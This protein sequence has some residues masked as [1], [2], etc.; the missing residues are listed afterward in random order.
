MALVVISTWFI[1]TGS[2]QADTAC[3]ERPTN[4]TGVLNA[5]HSAIEVSWDA[6]GGCTPDSYAV[7]RRTLHVGERLYKFATVSGSELTWVDDTVEP[8]KTYRYRVRSNDIGRRSARTD[9][10]VP[11]QS[12]VLHDAPPPPQMTYVPPPEPEVTEPLIAEQQ[13]HEALSCPPG[14]DS[15]NAAKVSTNSPDIEVTWSLPREVDAGCSTAFNNTLT[16]IGF[17]VWARKATDRSGA[18]RLLTRAAQPLSEEP[19]YTFEN[20][21][22]AEYKFRVDAVY[23][24][25]DYFDRDPTDWSKAWSN[26]GLDTSRATITAERTDQPPPAYVEEVAVG[27][28][29]TILVQRYIAWGRPD[30]YEEFGTQFQI[31]WSTTIT[32]AD[33]NKVTISGRSVVFHEVTR[34]ADDNV[35]ANKIYLCHD[36]SNMASDS[37]SDWSDDLCSETPALSQDYFADP[38]VW[39]KGKFL[40]ITDDLDDGF[41]WSVY[42]G[43]IR[44]WSR[45]TLSMSIRACSSRGCSAWLSGSEDD[46]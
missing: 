43:S 33:D 31:K 30:V 13:M 15:V 22:D 20:F 10:D 9:V 8:G 6:P 23:S 19:S 39:P 16:L 17:D 46:D 35:T 32:D 27:V 28:H 4:V 24:F 5:D 18:W 40:L 42:E 21:R 11:E 41:D 7:Y 44:M 1:G 38:R 14:P 26:S 25:K 2:V 36:A 3:N 45:D 37:D 29:A 34:D 12:P